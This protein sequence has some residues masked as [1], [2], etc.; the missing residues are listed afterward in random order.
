VDLDEAVSLR[1]LRGFPNRLGLQG[2]FMVHFGLIVLTLM[3]LVVWLVE[4]RMSTTLMQQT[5]LRGLAIGRSI[6][7]T[8]QSELLS[9]DYVSL[10]QAA[11]TAARDE[12][13]C[14][15][16]SSTR[17]LRGRL[18]RQPERQGA[19]LDD[20]VS[21]HGGRRQ[22][23]R[24]QEVSPTSSRGRP[25]LTSISRCRCES[26]DA[27]PL[28]HGAGRLSLAP[29]MQ[30]LAETRLLLVLLALVAVLIVLA[31]ARLLSRRSPNRSWDWPARPPASPPQPRSHRDE[32]LGGRTRRPGQQ[33]QQDDERAE[34]QPRRDSLP[35]SAP[36]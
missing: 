15:S 6:A 19:V 14:M 29:A 26:K 32:D 33:L 24:V 1:E 16:S 12:V 27:G 13:S 2:R 34:A 5:R 30:T 4:N 11:E 9:Y 25:Q 7:A 22:R 8:V 10:Q 21:R 17:R 31:S 23:L 36:R 3:A 18:Q 28:G 35:E 20:P